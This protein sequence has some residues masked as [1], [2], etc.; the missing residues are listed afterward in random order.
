[1]K[2]IEQLRPLSMEHHLSLVLANKAIKTAKNGDNLQIKQLCQKIAQEFESRWQ[3]H[4]ALEE[5]SIF[6]IF[7]ANYQMALTTKADENAMLTILLRDQHQQMRQLSTAMGE[8]ETTQLEYFGQLL[9]NHT[10]LE[11]RLLFPLISELFTAD[12]LNRVADYTPQK[13]MS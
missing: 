8:G 9:R 3:T 7:E 2:R 4:F 5:Q 10:R 6:A 13:T 12:E 1:M 11:E